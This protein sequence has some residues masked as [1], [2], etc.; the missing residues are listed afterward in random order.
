MEGFRWPIEFDIP[1]EWW[2]EA[3]MVDFIPASP[4]KFAGA[5]LWFPLCRWC[6]DWRLH[7]F[8]LQ[9]VTD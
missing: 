3:G 4:L 7:E 9:N 1:D 6:N 2:E 5:G 8:Y